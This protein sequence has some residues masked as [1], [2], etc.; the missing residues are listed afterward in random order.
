VKARIKKPKPEPRDTRLYTLEVFIID[1][2]ITG[3]FLKKNKELSR[4]IQ[5]R[6]DQ[7]LE[8]LHEEIFKAF[9]REEEHMYEFQ[10]GGKGPMDPRARHYV[11]PEA[12]HGLFAEPMP[13][14]K[15]NR[16]TIES[17]GLK[18]NEA[19]GYWFDFGND[20]WHQINVVAIED[21]VPPGKYPR[22]IKRIGE[23]PPQYI[24]WEK[25]DMD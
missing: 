21:E 22:V 12:T 5:I 14:G 7:S 3:K 4:T 16:K 18:V 23:S 17:L 1:G 8:V 6:G 25:E 20:W 19:F 10:I 11:L 15:V 13:A 24:D 2:P 9:D